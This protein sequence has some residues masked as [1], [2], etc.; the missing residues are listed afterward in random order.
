MKFSAQASS[1]SSSSASSGVDYYVG[2]VRTFSPVGKYYSTSFLAI[3]S[4]YSCSS[5]GCLVSTTS[6][7]VTN[8]DVSL[9]VNSGN[10]D[11]NTG[12]FKIASGG[13][14]V[15]GTFYFD[16]SKFGFLESGTSTASNGSTYNITLAG[17][18]DGTLLSITG[19][20][21]NASGPIVQ[22]VEQLSSVKVDLYNAL[23]GGFKA[24]SVSKHHRYAVLALK[25]IQYK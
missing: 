21:S 12:I 16:G 2:D 13:V 8:G 1:S 14:N 17:E 3:K 11:Q 6:H 19:V 18:S 20:V 25:H 15:G 7:A 24:A 5:G 22:L 4:S 10:L 23:I 9:Q